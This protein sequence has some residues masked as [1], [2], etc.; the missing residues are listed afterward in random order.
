MLKSEQVDQLGAEQA[1]T[2][3][4]QHLVIEINTT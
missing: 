1:M 2:E 4:T 3:T